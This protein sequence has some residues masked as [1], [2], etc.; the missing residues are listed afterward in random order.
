MESEANLVKAS[1]LEMPFDEIHG[2][3]FM[4]RR[5]RVGREQRAIP[6]RAKASVDSRVFKE[7]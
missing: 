1:P 5:E 3:L 2:T 4:A 6:K 7:F